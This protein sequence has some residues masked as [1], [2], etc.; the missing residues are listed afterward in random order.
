MPAD[1]QLLRNNY[2]QVHFPPFLFTPQKNNPMTDWI[3][4][5]CPGPADIQ[6]CTS[7]APSG[8]CTGGS[9]PN[10][11]QATV[12]LIKEFEGFVAQPAPDPIGLPTVGYGHLCKQSGCAEIKPKYSFPLTASTAAELLQDDLKGFESCISSDLH[13]TVK[14]NANQY[15]ALCSWAFNVGCGNVGGST[16][17]Q[18]LNAGGDPNTVAADE[19]PKWNK[20]GGNVLPGLTRRRAA[21]V[22]LFGTATGVGALPAC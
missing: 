1:I 8:D 10:V 19:L 4:S 12:D 13:N 18:R 15:G 3:H 5:L 16:L 2:C 9:P 20:A 17:V 22:K 21:E 11:N 7:K 6:C 14:L